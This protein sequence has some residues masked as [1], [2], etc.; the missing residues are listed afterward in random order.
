MASDK[1]EVHKQEGKAPMYQ[2]GV[3]TRRKLTL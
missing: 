3:V 2:P 1:S